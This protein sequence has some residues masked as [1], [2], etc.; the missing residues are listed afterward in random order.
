M[1]ER[2]QSGTGAAH[3][4]S[5]GAALLQDWV[6]ILMAGINGCEVLTWR[7]GWRSKRRQEEQNRD[8]GQ[9]PEETKR[10]I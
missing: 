7:S 10:L 9:F 3:T 4:Q 8:K 1:K 5:S 6:W 2:D